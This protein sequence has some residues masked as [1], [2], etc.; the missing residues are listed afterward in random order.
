VRRDGR[1]ITEHVTSRALTTDA[2][3]AQEARLLGW[4]D[5]AID[6]APAVDPATGS[7]RLPTP[8]PAPVGW[9][10]S[11][12]RP[13][14]ARPR[15]SPPA[16]SSSGNSGGTSSAGAVGQ[17][18]RRARRATGAPAATLAKLL[19]ADRTGRQLPPRGTT[20]IL[21][22]AGM[23]STEDLDHLVALCQRWDW[24]LIAVGDP[25]QLPSVT[26]GGMFAHWTDTL[27]AHR[28]EHI[29]RFD[30]PW[31]AEASLALRRGDPAAAVTYAATNGSAACIPPSSPN[32]SP[33][34]TPGH[35]PRRDRGH[36]HLVAGDG[37]GHQRRDPVAGPFR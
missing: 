27:P 24:R 1:P 33:A 21:D 20:L 6:P 37:P 23:A 9:C 10:S 12:A 32:R 19:H 22:E 26:R 8:S 16:S 3:L 15:P 13:E 2:V 29:H 18:R 35:R 11:S 17:G 4:A 5:T 25:E 36:H 28:L 34:P 31:Q 30:E 7:G 14:R